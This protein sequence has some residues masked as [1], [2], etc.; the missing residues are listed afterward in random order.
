MRGTA[1]ALWAAEWAYDSDATPDDPDW[2]DAIKSYTVPEDSTHNYDHTEAL[3]ALAEAAPGVFAEIFSRHATTTMLNSYGDLNK[4]KEPV[5]LLAAAE[6]SELWQ[7]VQ[8]SEVAG[9]LFWVL[10]GE[11]IEWITDVVSQPT[12]NI[13]IRDL[14]AAVQFQFGHRFPLNTLA[15]MLR[16]LGPEPDDLLRTLE[17]GS[18]SGEKH[19]RYAATLDEVRHLATSDDEEIARIGRR[20]IEIFEPRLA[21]A[22]VKARRAA[23]RGIRDR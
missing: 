12:F 1:A 7:H 13:S 19:E 15:V 6:R 11:D 8:N 16:P 23:V 18:F 21:D 9:E 3:K 2:L 5:R 17:V 4:W 10:A 14:L 22:L 20:G